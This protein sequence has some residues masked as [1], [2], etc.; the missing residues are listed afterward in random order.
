MQSGLDHLAGSEDRD[1]VLWT[2]AGAGRARRCYEKNG[3]RLAGGHRT[4]DFGDGRELPL[5]EY[6][7]PLLQRRPGQCPSRQRGSRGVLELV[8]L[9]RCSAERLFDLELDMDAHSAS[10]PG[11]ARLRPPAPGHAVLGPGGES[12]PGLGTW[13]G[14]GP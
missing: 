7:H 5:V 14:R 4:R 12:R 3:W 9:V 11:A 2:P 1:A 10:L 13:D 8:T 6:R